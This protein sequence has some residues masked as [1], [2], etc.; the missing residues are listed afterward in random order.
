MLKKKIN[1]SQ[2]DYLIDFDIPSQ[3]E[4]HYFMQPE[5]KLIYQVPFLDNQRSHPL[6]RAFF[7]PYFSVKFNVYG[8]YQILKRKG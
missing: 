4:P 2:C 3:R 5:W 8:A 6:F 1:I 7:I